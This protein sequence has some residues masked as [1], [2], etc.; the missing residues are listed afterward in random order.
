MMELVILMQIPVGTC[1][2]VDDV[3][4]TPHSLE[5][6]A[7]KHMYKCSLQW[8][9]Y[10]GGVADHNR[11]RVRRCLFT[12]LEGHGSHEC[13]TQVARDVQNA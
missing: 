6:V 8:P 9:K 2:S 12:P 3:P 4:M 5:D 13:C 7:K 11:L 1:A 10:G